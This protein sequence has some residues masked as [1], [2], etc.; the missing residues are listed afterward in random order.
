MF[1]SIEWD[2]TFKWICL[3]TVICC[4]AKEHLGQFAILVN[5]GKTWDLEIE[6]R[7]NL[8]CMCF[9]DIKLFVAK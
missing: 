1:Y 3:H 7:Y 4:N 2:V 5:R 9:G 8:I 6:V